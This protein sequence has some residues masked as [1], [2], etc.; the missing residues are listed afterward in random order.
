MELFIR[1]ESPAEAEA[2]SRGQRWVL[3]YAD[4]APDRFTASG[5]AIAEVLHLAAVGFVLDAFDGVQHHLGDLAVLKVIPE[6][7]HVLDDVVGGW[8]NPQ[9]AAGAVEGDFAEFGLELFLIAA[10]GRDGFDD[11][12]GGIVAGN[13]ELTA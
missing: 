1:N 7:V 6:D 3:G 10:A 12:A 13:T 4:A 5:D 8:I 11:Q 2:E 9:R